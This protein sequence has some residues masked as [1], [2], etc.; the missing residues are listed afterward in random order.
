MRSVTTRDGVS[1]LDRSRWL[2]RVI[3]RWLIEEEEG[4]WE[5][6]VPGDIPPLLRHGDE[7]LLD[8][9]AHA[10]ITR[11]CEGSP[12]VEP[13]TERGFGKLVRAAV[14]HAAA[15]GPVLPPLRW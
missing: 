7:L 5:W 11:L 1:Y 15:V 10:I 4:W 9:P 6:L 14:H 8:L 2:C 12:F 3:E 13:W